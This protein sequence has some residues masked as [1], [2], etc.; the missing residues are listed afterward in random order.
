[1]AINQK[2]MKILDREKIYTYKHTFIVILLTQEPMIYTF[3]HKIALKH[4]PYT[5]QR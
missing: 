3:I 5:T 2:N 4:L 1:M